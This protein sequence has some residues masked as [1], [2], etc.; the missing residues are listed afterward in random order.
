MKRIY[1]DNNATT[2]VD[3]RVVEVMLQEL[4]AGP[5][6]PSSIHAFGRA[7]HQRLDRARATIARCLRV[8]PGE[9]VF[10]SSGTEALNLAIVGLR[11]KGHIITSRIDHAAVYKTIENL[12]LPVTYLPVGKEGHIKISDL[13]RAIGPDTSMIVLSGVN[14]ETGVKNPVEEIAA[15][16]Q[17][18]GIPLVIDAVAWLGKEKFSI[19]AG[20][21]AMTFSGHKIHGPKG[22]GLL[23]IRK[24]CRI[25]PL[26]IGG[27]QEAL[28]RGG[29]ENLPGIVGL[30]KAI[31]LLEE[32]L[33]EATVRM[34]A[35]RDQFERG[36]EGGIINGTGPRVCNTSSVT[37]PGMDGEALLIQLDLA[38]IAASMG[39]ACSAG[40]L[41]P[42]R[43]LLNMGLTRDEAMST[44]RFSVSRFT[45]SE[46]IQ[47]ALSVLTSSK[48]FVRSC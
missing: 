3:P 15:I 20:V 31:E 28:R 11:P 32:E 16:A 36:L 5:S 13:E 1:L 47:E 25:E 33:P 7:A 21:S 8:A 48:I 24:G 39:S 41:E 22:I 35:L 12:G 42:S 44:I 26:M 30:A 17:R 46:E 6:N 38:G 23:F 4:K 45:T 34:A 2:Q 40:A 27:G 29:T 37:F 43:V 18:E 14:S 10:T 9:L 19:P